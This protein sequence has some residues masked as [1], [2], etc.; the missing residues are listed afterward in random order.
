MESPAPCQS[1]WNTHW[2][3]NYLAL[4]V[5]PSVDADMA[6]RNTKL[7]RH[8]PA[9]NTMLCPITETPLKFARAKGGSLWYS[10]YSRGRLVTLTMA[11]HFLGDD[12]AREIWIRAQQNG[13][14]CE[15]RCPGC[16]NPMRVVSEPRWLGTFDV[17]VCIPC[18]FIWFDPDEHIEIPH[19][20]DL[21]TPR[22]DSTHIQDVGNSLLEVSQRI[23]E[24]QERRDALVYEGP[25]DLTPR[26]LGML[27]LPVKDL[28]EPVVQKWWVTGGIALITILLQL[29]VTSSTIISDYGFYPAD[30][31]KNF[32]LNILSSTVLHAGWFHLI[33]NLYFFFLLSADLEGYLGS[34]K[35]ITLLILLAVGGDLVLCM[36]SGSP[37]LSHVGLSGVIM[38][39]LVVYAFAFPHHRFT[40][41][42]PAL[43]THTFGYG[44]FAW[45]R[46]YNWVRIPIG[47][48]AG[49]YV[50]FNIVDYFLYESSG[51]STVSY[52]GH[53]GGALAGLIYAMVF[54]WR[55]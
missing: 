37:D 22:G 21:L 18:N 54:I 33:T 29:A 24:R 50:G 48:M 14:T 40:H 27:G 31:T 47:V 7:I 12:G 49:F 55:Q 6:D 30:P 1:C 46:G 17:D 9:T 10:P 16:R 5:L 15:K 26:I 52:S 35:Y 34:L 43:H 4:L 2:I 38:G 45:L 53:I 3:R 11:K 51:I 44:G 13:Q 25:S 32:G 41:L 36:M 20:E 28:N 39:L 42:I 19:P 8:S 23:T